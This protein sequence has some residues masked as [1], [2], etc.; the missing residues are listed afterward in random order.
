MNTYYWI[1]VPILAMLM[2]VPLN[3][4]YKIYNKVIVNNSIPLEEIAP[5]YQE[6]YV[7]EIL[8]KDN[9]IDFSFLNAIK[10]YDEII[11]LYSKEVQE[12]FKEMEM[13]RKGIK[14][15]KAYGYSYDSVSKLKELAKEYGISY[16]TYARRKK[17]YMNNKEI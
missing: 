5:I 8:L 17:I 9:L 10:D 15:K 12:L 2:D 6:Q 3:K 16:S 1:G 7:N 14:I 4:V 11:P 13:I